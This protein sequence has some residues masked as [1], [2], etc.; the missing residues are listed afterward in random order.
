MGARKLGRGL[1]ILIA[2]DQAAARTEVLELDPVTIKPNPNQPRKRFSITDLEMLKT[3]ISREGILQP[4]LVRRV[5]EMHQ[6]VAGERRLR[7]AQELGLSRV[8]ALLVEVGD[9]RLLEVA[10]VENI[11]REDLNPIELAVAYRQLMEVKGWTHEGLAE[12][13]GLSRSA[14]SNT[15]RLLD[16]PEDIQSAIIREQITMGHAKILLSV[17]E[18]KEQRM[19]FE[20]IAE[21]KLTVRDLEAVREVGETESHGKSASPAL[22]RRPRVSQ[23]SPHI[24]SLEERFGERLG[25]RVRIREKNGRGKISIQFY[26]TDDFERIRKIILSGTGDE[27]A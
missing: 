6:V 10:L 26:S 23:K 18:P 21:E 8:P 20:R 25:T 5:G 1:D 9:D 2:R 19:L 11:Q 27:R 3:S 4:I 17:S 22:E 12:S 16:L 13:L 7:A 14:V 24:V 15:I